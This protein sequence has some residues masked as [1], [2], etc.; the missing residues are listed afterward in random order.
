MSEQKRT[1]N[2]LK[3]KQALPLSLKISLTKQRI[4]SW[5]NHWGLDGVY[6][7]FSG[8]KDSTVLLD[9]A[10]QMYP[11]I[12]AVFVDT[13]LEYPEIRNFVGT[14]DNVDW[15]KPK[16]SFKQVIKKYGYPFISKEVSECVAGARKY[17]TQIIEDGILATDRQTDRTYRYQL[18]K[19]TGRGAY[20]DGKKKQDLEF[21][22]D[23]LN[24]RMINKEGGNNRRL[25][26]MLGW[27]TNDK[28]RPIDANVSNNKSMFSQ[29]KYKFFL[30]ADF[31]ISNK[32]CSVMK[33]EPA[34]RYSKKTGRM[35]ITAQ[36][37]SES[38]LRTQKWIQNGCN[39]FDLKTPISNPMSFWTE[40]DVLQ[41]I[42]QYDLP[43]C[44]VYG[45]IVV[46]YKKMGQ[47]EGQ[48]SFD[49][50]EIQK[51]LKTT[52]CS[53]TGC[54]FCGFGCHLEKSGEGRFERMKETHP[55]QY[56]YIM[57]PEE[58][59]GLNY[60]KIIDWINENGN[61]NIKY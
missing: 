23:I 25:A 26:I 29:E 46:D 5:V 35:A 61:L 53:R 39:G 58:Q 31:E 28:D 4:R 54:M 44:S 55:A 52:G 49:E 17:L 8:G 7:S 51:P 2:D 19:L 14:F 56:D 16:M 3:E 36:M 30:D 9:I 42:Q 41:Y 47:L 59:G 12:K 6:I 24:K 18:D 27:L 45:D 32:C 13:G 60:K 15:V 21:L 22:A 48:I 11:N 40:Q 57:R 50:I 33:K 10:R 34:H 43:I 37:A 1:I 38:R 20:S